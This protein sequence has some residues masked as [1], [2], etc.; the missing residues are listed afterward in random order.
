MFINKIREKSPKISQHNIE[1]DMNLKAWENKPLLKLIYNSFYKLISKYICQSDGLI[2]ELGSGI[3]NVK[4]VIPNCLRTDLFPNLWIDQ[5]ENA[6]KLSFGNETVSNLILLD[7]FHHLKHPGTALKEFNRVLTDKGRVLIFEPYLSFFGLLVYGLIHHESLGLNKQIQWFAPNNWEPK[8]DAYY[9]AAGNSTRIFFKKK[10]L[11]CLSD[12]NTIR[13]ERISAFSYIASGGY[14]GPQ[15]Y[16]ISAYPFLKKIDKIFD[17][18]PL[19]CATRC[20][21]ILEKNLH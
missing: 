18:I 5:Q 11:P 14:S 16:P 13:K 17:Y 21:I 6:Y 19:L 15:L 12:W 7:V 3:G 2:V 20:L 10:F 1:I 4:E 9:A 8:N